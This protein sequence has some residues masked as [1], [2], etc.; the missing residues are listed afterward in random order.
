MRVVDTGA[1]SGVARKTGLSDSGV[2]RQIAQLEEH[3]GVRLLHRT[4]R[5]MSL[6]DDGE[7]LIGY[8][9]RLLELSFAM[10]TERGE[11]RKAP[12]GLAR[13]GTIMGAGLFLAPRLPQL[14]SR[15]PGLSVDLVVCD[16]IG[17]MVEA[18][19][20]LALCHGKIADSSFMAR[21][22]GM[23]GQLIFAAPS[24][25][26][27]HGVPTSPADLHRHTFIL[28]DVEDRQGVWQFKG[29]DGSLCGQ[30]CS[31]LSTNNERAALVMAQSGYGVACLPD[32][33]VRDDVRVGRLIRLMPDYKANPVTLSVVYPSRRSWRHARAPCVSS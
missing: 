19:L 29:P 31:Q 18:R 15:Y 26:D 8:A 14:L 3:F 28:R 27:R 32:M 2:T 17:A 11:H 7:I 16:H 13:L 25:L 33:R 20:D 24:Y 5:R 4:T 22:I 30:I 23:L 12:T 1:F 10:E 6:T 9:R 21:Q